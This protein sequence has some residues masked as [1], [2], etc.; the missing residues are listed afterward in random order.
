MLFFKFGLLFKQSD[1]GV[2]DQIWILVSCSYYLLLLII[3]ISSDAE[4]NDTEDDKS[5]HTTNDYDHSFWW[6]LL[7]V[8]KADELALGLPLDSFLVLIKLYFEEFE[9]IN[10]YLNHLKVFLA[11]F[12]IKNIIFVVILGK[13]KVAH[14]IVVLKIRHWEQLQ[15]WKFIYLKADVWNLCVIRLCAGLLL[16]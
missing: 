10:A 12:N 7:F 13:E 11:L 8:I 2:G 9:K 3:S 14:S 15:S 1:F 6:I 4:K 16:P 5:T